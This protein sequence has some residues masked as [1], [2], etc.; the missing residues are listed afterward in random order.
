MS[1][2]LLAK[3]APNLA[4]FSVF[5]FI[6]AEIIFTSISTKKEYHYAPSASFL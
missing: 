3:M 4:E 1:T 2:N 5:D 6:W